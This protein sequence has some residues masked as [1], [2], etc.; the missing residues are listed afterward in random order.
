[1]DFIPLPLV[2]DSISFA[3]VGFGVAL[4]L[5]V[6]LMLGVGCYCMAI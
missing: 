4:L 6:A 3:D 2:P 1:M 5:G